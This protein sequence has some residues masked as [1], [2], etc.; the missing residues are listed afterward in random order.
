ML[1]RI[2]AVWQL[3]LLLAVQQASD[4]HLCVVVQILQLLLHIVAK[5][6][7]HAHLHIK[8]HQKRSLRRD[9]LHL[10]CLV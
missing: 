3:L 6:D 10:Q 8:A 9:L 1:M 2:L 4:Q 5:A 7:A